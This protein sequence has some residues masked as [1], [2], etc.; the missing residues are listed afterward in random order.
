M[1]TEKQANKKKADLKSAAQSIPDQ[2]HYDLFRGRL[3]F[4][5]EPTWMRIALVVLVLAT[6]II[7]ILLVHL[8]ALPVLGIHWLGNLPGIRG[9]LSG[10]GRSP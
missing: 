2:S 6:P 3:T 4:T 5:T 1:P 8:Y 7:L 10:K 9:L